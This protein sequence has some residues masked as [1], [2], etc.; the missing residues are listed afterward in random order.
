MT[1]K[2]L[3]QR[4]LSQARP[5]SYST[6]CA[7]ASRQGV[8]GAIRR[9]EIVRVL[10]GFYAAAVY[11]ESWAVRARAAVSWAGPAAVI[12]GTSA[13][14][15]W[16]ATGRVPDTVDLVLPHGSHRRP[17]RWLRIATV[18][19]AVPHGLWQGDLPVALP[20]Y[21]VAQAYGRARPGDRADIVFAAFRSGKVSAA[22]MGQAL[23]RMPRVRARASLVAR[24]AYAAD[25]VESYL[26]ERGLRD[27]FAGSTFDHLLR[28]H[29]LVVEG[30][31]F[32]VDV[33]DPVT[34]TAFELDGAVAHGSLE[35]RQA[36]VERDGL[37]AGLGILTVRFTYRDVMDRPAWCRVLALR[38]LAERGGAQVVTRAEGA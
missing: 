32:R 28:Q 13:L 10:P 12:A 36:D 38:V 5:F 3:R 25:G 11:A 24:V 30:R 29:R 23:A 34:S 16:E 33:F 6:M 15:A 18:T 14:F 2:S 7:E 4:L 19:Y 17:P 9:G 8:D 21:A 37:L 31:R 26:E 22:S 35:Q 1:M 20:A 27:V